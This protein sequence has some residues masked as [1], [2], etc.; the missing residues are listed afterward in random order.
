MAHAQQV[1]E[2]QTEVIRVR[3]WRLD[4]M[5][6]RLDRF[7]LEDPDDPARELR[8]DAALRKAFILSDLAPQLPLLDRYEPRA[9][10]RRVMISTYVL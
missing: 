2:A 3:R 6:Q 9:V 5:K 10:S 4:L 7:L 8:R 1:A